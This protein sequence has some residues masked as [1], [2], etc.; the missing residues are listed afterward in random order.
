M[1][2]LHLKLEEGHISTAIVNDT[3]ALSQR[4]IK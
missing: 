3:I 4:L 1:L 2:K